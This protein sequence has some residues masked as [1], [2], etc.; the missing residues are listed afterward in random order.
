MRSPLLINPVD[1]L[2][3][4]N[5]VILTSETIAIDQYFYEAYSY[6]ILSIAQHVTQRAS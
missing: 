5:L 2:A 4:Q 6:P 3:L 1:L